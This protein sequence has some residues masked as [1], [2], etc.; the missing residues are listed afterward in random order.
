MLCEEALGVSIQN[1]L[2]GYWLA[3]PGGKADFP[4]P[5]RCKAGAIAVVGV[6]QREELARG[7]VL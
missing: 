7:S 3:V 5:V 2:E 1:L 6:A 4:V